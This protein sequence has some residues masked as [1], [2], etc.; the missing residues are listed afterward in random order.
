LWLDRILFTLWVE[1][2]TCLRAN[3][4]CPT[5]A[6]DHHEV[7]IVNP[8]GKIVADFQIEHYDADDVRGLVRWDQRLLEGLGVSPGIFSWRAFH[9]R[10]CTQYTAFQ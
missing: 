1:Y 10:S 7:V 5:G 8:S 2:V 3:K 9:S 4:L 6:H